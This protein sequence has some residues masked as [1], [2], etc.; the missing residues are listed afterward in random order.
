MMMHDE[1]GW[2]RGRG[3]LRGVL[4][5]AGG[6][7]LAALAAGLPGCEDRR[8]GFDEAVEEVEDEAKDARDEVKDEIDDHT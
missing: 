2:M 5:I 3:R 7:L 8:S 6:L 4:P 1:N